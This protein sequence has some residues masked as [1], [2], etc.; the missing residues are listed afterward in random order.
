MTSSKSSTSHQQ[1]GCRW[2]RGRLIPGKET[3]R[4]AALP[5]PASLPSRCH[6]LR[7]D[8]HYALLTE[9][10]S[11]RHARSSTSA[12]ML[13]MTT[14]VRSVRPSSCCRDGHQPPAAPVHQAVA[15][16][17]SSFRQP[18]VHSADC[19]KVSPTT[20]PR[21]TFNLSGSNFCHQ[22]VENL[23]GLRIG[24]EQQMEYVTIL[25]ILR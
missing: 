13:R 17:A 15:T 5:T 20:K 9:R 19:S 11:Q 10:S 3:L 12:V 2:Y 22:Q 24:H 8:S 23:E 16:P 1:H 14:R 4:P 21:P 6:R 25:F 7:L 18:K